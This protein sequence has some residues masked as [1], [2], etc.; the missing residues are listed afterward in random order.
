M[1]AELGLATWAQRPPRRGGPVGQVEVLVD[2]QITR[3]T[4]EDI[5]RVSRG[6]PRCGRIDE[7]R[8]HTRLHDELGTE[9]TAT[10]AV[11]RTEETGA[12]RSTAAKRS[13]L[14]KHSRQGEAGSLFRH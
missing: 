5:P 6:G 2:I 9:I 11:G 13:Q 3:P 8:R 7:A 14:P 10:I 12:P 1:A 4:K